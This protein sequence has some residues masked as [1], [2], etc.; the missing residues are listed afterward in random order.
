LMSPLRQVEEKMRMRADIE[1]PSEYM[2]RVVSRSKALKS[3]G[4]SKAKTQES[5]DD[6]SEAGSDLEGSDSEDGEDDDEDQ[7]DGSEEEDQ[8]RARG[9]MADASDE[10]DEEEDEE[11]EEEDESM[12]EVEELEAEQEANLIK[13]VQVEDKDRQKAQHA[14]NQRALSDTVL[15]ARIRMQKPLTLA[16]RLPRGD[17]MTAFCKKAKRTGDAGVSFASLANECRTEASELVEDLLALRAGLWAQNP[18]LPAPGE[19]KTRRETGE[20][21]DGG[22]VGK[23][24]REDDMAALWERVS[25]ADEALVPFRDATVDK[26]NS[27]VMLGSGAKAGNKFKALNQTVLNQITNTLQVC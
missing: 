17:A 20:A 19:W 27:K 24:K 21:E 13:L 11:D 25:A 16:A 4:R 2:G 10:E 5:D 6:E 26:W 18:A 7:A 3:A 14:R 8:E 9:A 23:R 15:E 12:R 1:L 22:G